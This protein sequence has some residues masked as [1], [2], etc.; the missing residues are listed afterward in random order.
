M[1]K[2]RQKLASGKA[3]TM[4]N[5]DFQSPRL[6]EHL[7]TF[8]LDV[9]FL[10]GERMS[11]DFALIEE[12]VRAAH[13]AGI[14]CMARPWMN[15]PGLIT[16][17]MDCGL[18]GIAF[19]HVE[20]AASARG[21]VEVVRDSVV[22]LEGGSGT[23]SFEELELELLSGPLAATAA[24]LPWPR[25]GWMPLPLSLYC[26]PLRPRLEKTAGTVQGFGM[27]LV[28]FAFLLLGVGFWRSLRTAPKPQVES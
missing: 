8:G 13:V 2:V 4:F 1:N 18:D 20:D 5:V 11:Y 10:D 24:L 3:V 6:V 16:R 22:V 27:L 23:R 19:P 25:Y 17:Y 28:G 7:A 15:E 9:C 21:L 26:S 12:M 14:A